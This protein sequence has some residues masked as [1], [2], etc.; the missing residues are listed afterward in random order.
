MS[1][2]KQTRIRKRPGGP[3]TSLDEAPIASLTADLMMRGR[4]RARELVVPV[5][6]ESARAS[7]GATGFRSLLPGGSR[8]DIALALVWVAVFVGCFLLVRWSES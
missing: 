4:K 3:S 2:R 5:I 1:E 8:R 6:A 7:R